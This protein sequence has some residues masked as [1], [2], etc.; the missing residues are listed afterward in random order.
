MHTQMGNTRDALHTQ[1]VHLVRI[2][3]GLFA[4]LRLNQAGNYCKTRELIYIQAHQ[5]KG[6]LHAAASRS[7]AL[8]DIKYSSVPRVT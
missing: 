5:R 6:S 1:T 3:I 8:L 7:R 4:R 2:T